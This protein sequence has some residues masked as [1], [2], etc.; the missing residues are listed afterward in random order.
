MSPAGQLAAIHQ[1]QVHNLTVYVHCSQRACAMD[2]DATRTNGVGGGGGGGTMRNKS[3][4]GRRFWLTGN[5]QSLLV[6]WRHLNFVTALICLS[7]G[8]H[9]A[10]YISFSC[11]LARSLIS[12]TALHHSRLG[13]FRHQASSANFISQSRKITHRPNTHTH[14]H[15]CH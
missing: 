1:M 3:N 7:L 8:A 4:K 2:D 13:L 15:N 6:V 9:L 14:T 5:G 12:S 10:A 11:S